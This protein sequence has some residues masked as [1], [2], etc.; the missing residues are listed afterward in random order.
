[1]T[2]QFHFI[3][4]FNFLSLLYFFCVCFVRKNQ[5]HVKQT[6]K[7]GALGLPLGKTTVMH[8]VPRDNLPEP[9]S[10]GEFNFEFRL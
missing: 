5:K 7:T 3:F 9:N 10:Q 8:L 2:K 1:M 4:C 6:R